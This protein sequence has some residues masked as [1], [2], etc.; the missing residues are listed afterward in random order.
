M[1]IM[2]KPLI[3]FARRG[4]EQYSPA[5]KGALAISAA[6]NVHSL[7]YVIGYHPMP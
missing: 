3:E 7:G 1:S 6:H 5:Q 2:R 4:D